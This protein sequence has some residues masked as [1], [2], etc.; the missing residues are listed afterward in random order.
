VRQV[1]FDASA[2][3][4]PTAAVSGNPGFR[5]VAASICESACPEATVCVTVDAQVQC[6]PKANECVQQRNYGGCYV[7]DDTDANGNRL[8]ACVN[9]VPALQ[10]NASATVAGVTAA[11][12]SRCDCGTLP[13]YR[14]NGKTCERLCPADRCLNK[15]EPRQSICAPESSGAQLHHRSRRTHSAQRTPYTH[16]HSAVPVP[17]TCPVTLHSGQPRPIAK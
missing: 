14:G 12:A 6:V 8:T 16:G 13:C 4:A 15:E 17:C 5:C 2:P 3:L 7:S 9:L 11:S 10:R 1:P